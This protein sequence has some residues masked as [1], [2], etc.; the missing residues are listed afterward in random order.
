MSWLM[1]FFRLPRRAFGGRRTSRTGAQPISLRRSRCATVKA[2]IA[3][4]LRPA[5]MA[6]QRRRRGCWMLVPGAWRRCAMGSN[7]ISNF[8]VWRRGARRQAARAN[9]GFETRWNRPA[10]AALR[11]RAI[12]LRPSTKE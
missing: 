7:H 9:R 11:V 2:R 1:Q 3:P 12:L 10:R 8:G 4:A 6:V 5:G